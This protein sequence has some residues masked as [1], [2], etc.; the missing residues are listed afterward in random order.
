MFLKNLISRKS[1]AKFASN[2][3]NIPQEYINQKRPVFLFGER[4]IIYSN[5][6]SGECPHGVATLC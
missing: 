3:T 6:N 5:V 4:S 1:V 2:N